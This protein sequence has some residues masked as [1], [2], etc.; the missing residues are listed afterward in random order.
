MVVV[1]LLF[2]NIQDAEYKPQQYWNFPPIFDDNKMVPHA[3]QAQR[4]ISTLW[5]LFHRAAWEEELETGIKI[6]GKSG[7]LSPLVRTSQL[8]D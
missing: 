7:I 5:R 2:K 4:Y 3:R 6:R 1:W 8:D